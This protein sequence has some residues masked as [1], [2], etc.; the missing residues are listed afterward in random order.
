MP[1]SP[2]HK[3]LI[4]ATDLSLIVCEL[5]ETRRLLSSSPI[6]SVNAS[7]SSLLFQ[8][9]PPKN[10]P[11]IPIARSSELPRNVSG[12]I[13]ALYELSL[14][15]HPQYQSAAPGRV[16]KAPMFPPGYTGPKRLNLDVIGARAQFNPQTGFVLSGEVLGPIDPAQPAIYSFLIKRGG[17]SSTGPISSQST[18]TYDSVVTVTMGP[19]PTTSTISLLNSTGQATSTTSLPSSKVR[20]NGSTINVTLPADVYPTMAPRNTHTTRMRPSFVFE[21]AVPGGLS[22]DIAG[23]TPELT[24]MQVGQAGLARH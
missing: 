10:A 2:G 8:K 18:V 14:T 24:M 7:L 4:C 13:Q 9:A 22:G 1:R 12:R 11:V 6:S 19:S 17:V 23:F 5:L 15:R 3:R 16:L 21:T 20:V